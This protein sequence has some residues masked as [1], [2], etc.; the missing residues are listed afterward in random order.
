M[1][2]DQFA[3]STRAVP[4]PRALQ[5]LVDRGGDLAQLV[6][7][8]K[9]GNESTLSSVL[10][11]LG[12]T[13]LGARK[14]IE[15][16]LGEAD[17][18]M[19]ASMASQ[20]R[21]TGAPL[22]DEDNREALRAVRESR[23][24]QAKK[25]EAEKREREATWAPKTPGDALVRA[26]LD[27]ESGEV[28]RLLEAHAADA[29]VI[30]FESPGSASGGLPLHSAA[31]NGHLQVVR[32]LL[33]ARAQ[34][35]QVCKSNH[36]ALMGACYWGHP[37][38]VELLLLHGADRR[39]IGHH[40][41]SALRLAR[42]NAPPINEPEFATSA[43]SEIVWLLKAT[44]RAPD[45]A[46][47]ADNEDDPFLRERVPVTPVEER[48]RLTPPMVAWCEA[49]LA[50]AAGDG[51]SA[52]KHKKKLHWLA[53]LNACTEANVAYYMQMHLGDAAGARV[54]GGSW[55]AFARE[56]VARK[57]EGEW[58]RIPEAEREAIRFGRRDAG[59]YS[60][61][62]IFVRVFTEA[63]LG[64]QLHETGDGNIAVK[65]ILDKTVR[66]A[67]ALRARSPHDRAAPR[68]PARR[69]TEL[70]AP[71]RPPEETRSL[72]QLRRRRTSTERREPTATSDHSC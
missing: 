36:T 23:E 70:A 62:G 55:S 14:R 39:Q 31:T 67:A 45:E 61:G 16:A 58:Q 33:Q 48:A 4:L 22:N 50:L 37:E 12:Y 51:G 30:N 60:D 3:D 40:G 34:I 64:L 2:D 43:F 47:E 46:A 7:R 63:V 59:E 24:Q 72:T 21:P 44:P 38:V 15:K 10:G 29:D 13:T 41:K 18:E 71:L 35:N 57:R 25:E 6:A 52:G 26:A 32:L 54:A 20:C 42:Q 53:C 27:G 65:A 11:S 69:A 8:A 1:P 17:V 19:V 56:F 49:Q 5:D 66:A 9:A 28:A 68:A